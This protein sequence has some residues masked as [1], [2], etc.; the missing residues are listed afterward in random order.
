MLRTI[1]TVGNATMKNRA[2]R[3]GRKPIASSRP[4]AKSRRAETEGF[5]EPKSSRAPS[6]ASIV[7]LAAEVDALAAEL[8]TSRARIADLE[9]RVDIDPLTDVLNRRGFER[10]LKRSLAYV[11]RYGTSAALIYVDLD[12][13]KPVNDRH[14]HAAGD[15]VLKAIAVAL[16]RSVRAS[17][18]VARVGGDEFAV[19]LWNVAG[20]AAA[21]KA[22]AL[23][24]AVYSTQV[25]W[26][27]ST[28]V[29]GASAGVALLGPLDTSDEVLARA[30]A[31]MYARKAERAGHSGSRQRVQPQAGPMRR[32]RGRPE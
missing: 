25:C 23:E 6:R 1:R 12:G 30:D 17:D 21:A 22:A 13:F 15:A 20:A 11:K 26:G 4:G 5:A 29:V 2:A 3:A 27:A 18:V 24:T 9:A 10:E 7:R 19:L 8:K 16:V 28:F 32:L 14:G 31:A